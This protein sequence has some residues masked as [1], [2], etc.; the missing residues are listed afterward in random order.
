MHRRIQLLG[1][2]D[3]VVPDAVA[4]FQPMRVDGLRQIVVAPLF[5][6]D[7]RQ[8]VF[9]FAVQ[10]SV[11]SGR[12][13]FHND[14]NRDEWHMDFTLDRD[15]SDFEWSRLPCL[16]FAAR[17]GEVESG[18]IPM[19]L[20]PCSMAIRFDDGTGAV[21]LGSIQFFFV[22]PSELTEAQRAAIGA[23]PTLNRWVRMRVGCVKCGD[24]LRAITGL[25]RPTQAK[26]E[27]WIWYED[28]PDRFECSC[29]SLGLPLRY[30]REGMHVLIAHTN[31]LLPDGSISTVKAVTLDDV[32]ATLAE[33]L[34]LLDD[35]P[36]EQDV[37]VFIQRNLLLLSPFGATRLFRKP[38]ILTKCKADFGII[39]SRGE[40]LLIEIERPGL[41]LL[42]K[43]GVAT[44]DLTHAFS[45]PQEWRDIIAEHRAAVLAGIRDCPQQISRVRYLVIAGRS[46]PYNPD[47]LSRLI[48][49]H[50][51]IEFMT[52]DH[53]VDGV[54]A[55]FRMAVS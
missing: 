1:V 19:A 6:L 24:G 13:T 23:S 16:I 37:Q 21:D 50:D 2:A 43:D 26:A 18:A 14:Q 11:R 52:Y 55:A 27:G 49:Y 51:S 20:E 9:L 33:F 17:A 12:L 22:P 3:R 15:T 29:G 31:A 40:L 44:A 28:L 34:Q 46:A 41:P 35:E 42:R 7:L 48:R 10:P 5:P 25:Q 47:H 36:P 30:L 45:Q 54:R 38:P 8:F 4:P 39:T 32:E 53:L